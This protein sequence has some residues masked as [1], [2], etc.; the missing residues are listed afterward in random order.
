V[1]YLSKYTPPPKFDLLAILHDVCFGLTKNCSGGKSNVVEE[2]N[3]VVAS[4]WDQ[5]S[6]MIIIENY[7]TNKI[8]I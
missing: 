8:I 6:A 4:A 1:P 7:A 3:V 5:L 2:R